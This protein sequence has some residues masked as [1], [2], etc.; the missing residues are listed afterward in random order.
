[1]NFILM[2]EYNTRSQE[3]DSVV[4]SLVKFWDIEQNATSRF[5]VLAA[6]VNLGTEDIFLF[7]VQSHAYFGDMIARNCDP[8]RE[9][10]CILH[11]SLIIEPS[12]LALSS[13]G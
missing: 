13:C 2:N 12:H 6:V 8:F 4:S 1:M 7:R 9:I 10:V 3:R 11:S 5:Q